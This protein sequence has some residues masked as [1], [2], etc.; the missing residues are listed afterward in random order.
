MPCRG[1][2][3]PQFETRSQLPPTGCCA[4]TPPPRRRHQIYITP[5]SSRRS[6]VR[7]TYINALSLLSQLDAVSRRARHLADPHS[8]SHSD[9]HPRIIVRGGVPRRYSRP[10]AAWPEPYRTTRIRSRTCFR[11]STSSH[12]DMAAMCTPSRESWKSAPRPAVGGAHPSPFASADARSARA[13]QCGDSGTLAPVPQ[14]VRPIR[15]VHMGL[16]SSRSRC[17][18]SARGATRLT[19]RHGMRRPEMQSWAERRSGRCRFSR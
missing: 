10:R 6:T 5:L 11:S 14:P 17:A 7:R 4:R 15:H 8:P 16:R 13:G 12:D 18:F 9:A 19:M 3:S 2:P 1:H